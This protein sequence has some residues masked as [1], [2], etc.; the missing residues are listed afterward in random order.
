MS[1]SPLKLPNKPFSTKE[2]ISLGISKNTL[3]RM[4]E[5]GLIQRMSRGIYQVS[6]TALE[7]T[8]KS[9]KG[10]SK[11]GAYTEV[12]K[13]YISAT[14]KC[15]FPSAICLLSALEYYN[16]TDEI[17]NR[18]WMMVPDPKRIRS[19]AIKL[20]RSRNPK[21]DIGIHKTKDYWI[22]T[23]ERT[24]IDCVVFKRIV[25]QQVAL[26]ALRL[27]ISDRKIKLSTLYELAR[28]MGVARL[29]KPYIEILGA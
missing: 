8:I 11:K 21:W 7:V 5:M 3:S 10:S 26:S 12:E 14:L 19:D 6:D 25:G 13:D 20:V 1:K 2:A 24:L 29:I 9:K 28:S 17:T 4:V 15:G 16:L 22:T 18:T 23:I 27:A